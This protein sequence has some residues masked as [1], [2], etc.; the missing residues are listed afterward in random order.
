VGVILK[1]DPSD[2]EYECASRFK[3]A[4]ETD[5]SLKSDQNTLQI[6]PSVQCLGQR[7]KDVDIVCLGK[8]N[9]YKTPS[10]TFGNENKLVQVEVED[11]CVTVEIKSHTADRVK[12]EGSKLF[13]WYERDRTYKDASQQSE[14]QKYSLIDYLKD[15]R[16]RNPWV[17]NFIYLPRVRKTHLQNIPK[18]T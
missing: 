17:C 12:I 15:N 11:L 8:F 7:T 1:G 5:K 13:V 3:S 16:I 10:L 6:I 9:N 18:V 2:V 4:F 14:Q